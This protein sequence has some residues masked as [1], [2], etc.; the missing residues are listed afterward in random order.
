MEIL[1]SYSGG[2]ISYAG[3]AA[4]KVVCKNPA[5]VIDFSI[6]E[7]PRVP[8]LALQASQL[9]RLVNHVSAICRD[10]TNGVASEYTNVIRGF[11]LCQTSV[12][13]GTKRRG[14][15]K[16]ASSSTN[17]SRAMTATR[18]GASAL[19]HPQ[20]HLESGRT[21]GLGEQFSYCA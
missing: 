12:P 15:A 21:K 9:C 6:L 1:C 14:Q 8:I 4:L 13:L 3:K 16:A 11:G 19:N 7:K 17:F 20:R 10:D 2:V 18:E 5:K